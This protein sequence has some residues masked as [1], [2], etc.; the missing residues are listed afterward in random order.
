MTNIEMS[1]FKDIDLATLS[2]INDKINKF[3]NKVRVED[4][5]LSVNLKVIHE[6]KTSEKYEITST[7]K[8]FR[9]VKPTHIKIEERDLIKGINMIL[10]KLERNIE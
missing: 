4:F 7:F 6:T 9:Q 1:G 3:V 5:H 2:I 8:I 10:K